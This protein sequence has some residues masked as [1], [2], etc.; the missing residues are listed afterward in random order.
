[1]RYLL[2]ES[3]SDREVRAATVTAIRLSGDFRLEKLVKA[4]KED[5]CPTVRRRILNILEEEITRK[6][7]L[8]CIE[9]ILNEVFIVETSERVRWKIC[10]VLGLFAVNGRISADIQNEF[11]KA[12]VS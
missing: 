11:N 5:E 9:G 12:L 3:D 8:E 7:V 2:L 4:L 1:M 6:D 10:R